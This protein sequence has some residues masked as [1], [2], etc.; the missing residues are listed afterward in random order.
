MSSVIMEK[1]KLYD[2]VDP[3]TI[4][5]RNRDGIFVAYNKEPHEIDIYRE[6]PYEI[7][8]IGENPEKA[9]EDLIKNLGK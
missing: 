2:L 1:P 8:G 7:I 3:L 5:R 4:I 6:N 9:T